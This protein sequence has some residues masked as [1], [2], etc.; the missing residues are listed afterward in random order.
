M[1]SEPLQSIS[2]KRLLEHLRE[3]REAHAAVEM[4]L[5]RSV[6]EYRSRRLRK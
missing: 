4:E 6:A 5:G 1:R 3:L 2:D